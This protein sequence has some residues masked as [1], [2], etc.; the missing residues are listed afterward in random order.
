MDASKIIDFF[1]SLA[2]ILAHPYICEMMQI[3]L[4]SESQK[5]IGTFSYI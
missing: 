2:Y 4:L 5:Y 1:L 3:V